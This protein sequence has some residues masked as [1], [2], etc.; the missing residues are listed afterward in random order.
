MQI[1]QFVLI[2]TTWL[3]PR[4]HM[5]KN[6]KPTIQAVKV[7]KVHYAKGKL[8]FSGCPPHP[9]MTQINCKNICM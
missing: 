9:I 8:T 4:V 6:S 2:A 5:S 7:N 1:N 3:V